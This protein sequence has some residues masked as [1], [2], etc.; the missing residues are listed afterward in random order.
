MTLLVQASF[1]HSVKGP[2]SS[3]GRHVMPVCV[4]CVPCVCLVLLEV[5]GKHQSSRWLWSAMCMLGLKPGSSG[6]AFKGCVTPRGLCSTTRSSHHWALQAYPSCRVWHNFCVFTDWVIF[7][8]V[9][10]PHTHPWTFLLL[11]HLCG[12]APVCCVTVCPSL[13]EPVFGS[14]GSTPTGIEG[15]SFKLFP[16][17]RKL[18]TV[19]QSTILK[20]CQLVFF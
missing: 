1:L 15:P 14:S 7:H 17:P 12:Q 13:S 6:R 19:F 8:A 2:E 11:P 4:T 10:R 3:R 16:P 18:H 20:S 5:R 9:Y